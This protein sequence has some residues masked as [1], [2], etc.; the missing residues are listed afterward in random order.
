MVLIFSEKI[1]LKIRKEWGL[2]GFK[3]FKNS[4]DGIIDRGVDRTANR[5]VGICRC[6]D[7]TGK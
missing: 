6:R 5:G 7:F 4:A 2:N 1:N 3:N